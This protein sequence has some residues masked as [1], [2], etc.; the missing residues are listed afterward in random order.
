MSVFLWSQWDVLKVIDAVAVFRGESRSQTV[1]AALESLARQTLGGELALDEDIL[2]RKFPHTV[3]LSDVR[4]VL[5]GQAPRNVAVS[6]TPVEPAMAR[7]SA[8]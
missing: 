7:R 3:R 1:V 5:T 2:L 4:R 8:S 6:Q